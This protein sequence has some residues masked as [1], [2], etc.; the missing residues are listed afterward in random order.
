MRAPLCFNIYMTGR[1]P[2]ALRNGQVMSGASL[3]SNKNGAE[4]PV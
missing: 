4:G 2:L 3:S 1:R